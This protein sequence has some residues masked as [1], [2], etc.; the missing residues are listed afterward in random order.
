MSA[1]VGEIHTKGTRIYYIVSI[2][3]GN[4][5]RYKIEGTIMVSFGNGKNIYSKTM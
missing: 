2:Y 5:Y 1:K 3:V 4:R